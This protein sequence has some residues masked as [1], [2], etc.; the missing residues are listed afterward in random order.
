MLEVLLI[1]HQTII[2]HG[3]VSVRLINVMNNFILLRYAF[4]RLI[5]LRF[6]FKS[7]MAKA[8]DINKNSRAMLCTLAQ[9][10]QALSRPDRAMILLDRV[11]H[12]TNITMYIVLQALTI[13]P[14]DVACRYNRARLLFETKQYE[15]CVSEL[16]ELKGFSPDEAYI[17]HLLGNNILKYYHILQNKF[18]ERFIDVLG[19]LIWL[20]FTTVGPLRWILVV[21][22]CLLMVPVPTI[23]MMTT[24]THLKRNDLPVVDM[25]LP[26]HVTYSLSSLTLLYYT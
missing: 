16:N 11:S 1:F 26:S 18:Q 13:N 15:K 22:R 24:R 8:L 7:N 5:I 2:V 4:S 14:N 12:D 25:F 3:M 20:F 9:V 10:E 23:A 21:N 17:F 19:T 6:Y